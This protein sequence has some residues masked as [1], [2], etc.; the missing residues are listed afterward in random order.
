[1][2][3]H[4]RLS[5]S[6]LAYFLCRSTD[7]DTEEG[8]RLLCLV[9]FHTHAHLASI[10][11]VAK[12]QSA[13][14]AFPDTS[15]LVM[16]YNSGSIATLDSLDPETFRRLY[17]LQ[18]QL[19]RNT[20]HTSGLNP[21]SHRAVPGFSFGGASMKG[22]LDAQLFLHFQSIPFSKQAEI[23]AQIGQTRETILRD[24]AYLEDETWHS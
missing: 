18:S 9:E 15:K 13:S 24:C 1:M 22:I 12:H 7:M 3:P 8:S 10:I 17:L 2:I 6:S 23:T 14:D 20:Q 11:R 5:L 21:R 16:V 19:I 4:V